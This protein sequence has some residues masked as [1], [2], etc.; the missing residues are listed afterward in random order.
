MNQNLSQFIIKHSQLLP[1]SVYKL[2]KSESIQIQQEG[3]KELISL[4]GPEKYRNL[5]KCML[6]KV[7]QMNQSKGKE[8]LGFNHELLK[9]KSS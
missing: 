3:K 4:L 7:S 8:K 5:V 9:K 2:W 6:R 1:K